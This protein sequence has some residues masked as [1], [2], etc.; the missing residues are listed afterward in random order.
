MANKRYFIRPA[1]RGSREYNV[2]DGGT[3]YGPAD[4]IAMYLTKELAQ[5][6]RD[7]LNA[8]EER[9]LAQTAARDTRLRAFGDSISEHESKQWQL[10]IQ[11]DSRRKYSLARDCE[12]FVSEITDC[13]A[14][15]RKY[16][17]RLEAHAI[18]TK[19]RLWT[20][21]FQKD[22]GQ[23]AFQAATDVVDQYHWLQQ[24]FRATGVLNAALRVGR[25]TRSVETMLNEY[26]TTYGGDYK[27]FLSTMEARRQQFY[28]EYDRQHSEFA[29]ENP[30]ALASA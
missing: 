4:A 25:S 15:L 21:E 23:I 9:N 24:Q 6:K 7:E 22:Q 18:S 29:P 11:I 30:V 10:A 8:A 13:V 5:R 28:E 12:N 17:A 14:T 2:Y 19:D 20:P 1:G 26:A 16:A 3:G 27:E